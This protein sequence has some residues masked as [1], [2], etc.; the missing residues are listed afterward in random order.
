MKNKTPFIV[1]FT[2]LNFILLTWGWSPELGAAGKDPKVAEEAKLI[3]HDA[4]VFRPDPSYKDTAYDSQ[5]QLKI[6]GDKQAFPTPRPLL[7]LGRKIYATGEFS[8]PSYFLGRKNPVENQFLLFGDLRT[9]ASYFETDKTNNTAIAARMNLEFD[10]KLTATERIHALMRPIE[11]D[12]KLT[13]LE[14]NKNVDGKKKNVSQSESDINFQALYFEGDMGSIISG[15]RGSYSAKDRPFA[16]GIMPLIFQNGVWVDDA[17]TG[18]AFSFP[19]LHSKALDI[20]NMD[21]T[22]FAGFDKVGAPLA[23]ADEADVQIYGMAAFIEANSGY[24]EL[25]YG[26]TNDIS[27]LG[28][29]SYHNMTVAFTRRYGG[30]LSN[31]VRLIG[32]LGQNRDN[33]AP[34]TADGVLLLIE[35]SWITRLPS[36]LVPYVNLFYGSQKPQALARDAGAGGVLKNTG[37]VFEAGGLGAIPTMDASANDTAGIAFGIQYLF[38]LNQQLVFEVASLTDLSDT[39]NAVAGDQLGLGL[40]YQRALGKAWIVRLDANAIKTTNA[41][42]DDLLSGINLEL[43][44]KF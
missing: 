19:A 38:S 6:Y 18:L 13:R 41:K 1:A 22:F 23:V 25:G 44:R 40:R 43:R 35:N 3:P 5:A 34:V 32:N 24:W 15:M 26:Y 39:D 10:W 4:K 12:G 11:K 9:G 27:N 36:T 7:E 28:D 2:L 29:Q 33:N 37:L 16:I 31:S 20:S 30:W 14:F 42:N 21:F 8:P 17:F